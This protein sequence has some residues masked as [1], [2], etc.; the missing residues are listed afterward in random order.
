MGRKRPDTD[1][2]EFFLDQGLDLESRT[3]VVRPSRGY[4]DDNFGPADT[5]RYLVALR[6]LARSPEPLTVVLHSYGGSTDGGFALVDYLESLPNHVTIEVWGACYS[7]A[8]VI[9]QT[10]DTRK[11][12]RRS[13]FLVH[14]GVDGG[15]YY[16]RGSRKSWN[17]LA[18]IVD[19]HYEDLLLA[20]IQE[21]HAEFTRRR[22]QAWLSKD[23]IL[24]AEACLSWN[25]VDEI[26]GGKE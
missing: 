25:L 3:L 20:R 2:A 7:M 18:D 21:K 4:E 16:N 17:A 24:S 11:M 5:T 12:S 6:I 23:T 14:D 1:S 22:L 26:I 9:L 13:S 19:R 8:A 15:E 10:G